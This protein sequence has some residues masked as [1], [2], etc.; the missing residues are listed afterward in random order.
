[1]LELLI[2]IVIAYV[3]GS[4]PTSIIVSRLKYKTDILRPEAPLRAAFK[5][6]QNT[7]TGQ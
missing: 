6:F 4:I 3:I 1:M 7:A 2:L 5:V